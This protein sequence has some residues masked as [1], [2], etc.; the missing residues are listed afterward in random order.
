MTTAHPEWTATH[1]EEFETVTFNR[2]GEIIAR[3]HHQAQM[4]VEDLGK[5]VH[6]ELAAIPGGAFTMGS[7][8]GSGYEDETPRHQVLV[9]PFWMA[10]Y[11][12]TQ[13]QWR[14]LMGDNPYC[15]FKGDRLPVEY[16]SWTQAQEFCRRLAKVTGRAYQFPAEAQ[17]E[18][19]CRAGSQ[20]PFYCGETI[21]TDYANY[22]GEHIFSSEPEGLYR[23]TTTPVGSFPPNAFGLYDMAGNLWEWCA[24]AWHPNYRG[25]PVTG[26]AWETGGDPSCRVTRG[27]SWHE[28]PGHC[29]SAVRVRFEAA[30]GDEQVG[31]RVVLLG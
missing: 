22:C 1:T 12:V 25:A 15:R 6:L 7:P 4:F 8:E 10:K 2:Q 19:A 28:I 24:D 5:G 20:A 27:G 11:P 31:F 3:A 26:S 14:V 21:T 29:R 9:A 16:V 13:Q 18:Y 30:F 23:H 17:W